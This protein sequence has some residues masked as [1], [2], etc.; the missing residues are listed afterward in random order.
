MPCGEPCRLFHDG[1]PH[2]GLA[3][4][5]CILLDSWP[6]R[7]SGNA[8]HCVIVAGRSGSTLGRSSPRPSALC[9]WPEMALPSPSWR[10]RSRRLCATATGCC[11]TRSTWALQRWAAGPCC[12][13]ALS[14][15]R[16]LHSHLW[17]L[18]IPDQAL[19]GHASRRMSPACIAPAP[20][21]DGSAEAWSTVLGDRD[22]C[23][24]AGEGG[25]PAGGKRGLGA[26][27]AW[28]HHCSGQ[29]PQLPSHGCHEPGQRCG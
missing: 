12:A 26:W 10:G 19:S 15:L 20:S 25:R 23:T 13:G 9:A 18:R 4:P 27:R 21:A 29:A 22:W 14:S 5:V 3:V 7:P 16:C 28:G 1:R 2:G 24:G 6:A 8:P 17:V 11:W